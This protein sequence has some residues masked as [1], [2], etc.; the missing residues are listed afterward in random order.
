[1]L[2]G[3]CGF[4]VLVVSRGVW[5]RVGH[6]Y[7]SGL[8]G[9]FGGLRMMLSCGVVSLGSPVVMAAGSGWAGRSAQ[10]WVVVLAPNPGAWVLLN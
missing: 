9:G 2:R 6:S 5:G 7:V 1:M 8:V 4:G 3:P 10:G